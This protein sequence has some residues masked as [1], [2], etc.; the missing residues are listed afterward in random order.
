MAIA[1][2]LVL[3]ALPGLGLS[4][5]PHP[6]VSLLLW[7][8]M[9][10]GSHK[11]ALPWRMGSQAEPGAPENIVLRVSDSD[12]WERGLPRGLSQIPVPAPAR[13]AQLPWV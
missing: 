9:W 5:G 7:A 10:S 3:P 4:V 1:R 2:W 11:A 12:P 8:S 13:V 6:L